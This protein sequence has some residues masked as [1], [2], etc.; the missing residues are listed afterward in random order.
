MTETPTTPGESQKNEFNCRLKKEG[1]NYD[2]KLSIENECLIV[3]I[4]QKYEDNAIEKYYKESYTIDFLQRIHKFFNLYD[5][6]TEAFN[7]IRSA[8]IKGSYKLEDNE[9]EIIL[10]IFC[11]DKEIRLAIQQDSQIDDRTITN[12]SNY[13]Q[14]L[15]EKFQNKMREIEEINKIFFKIKNKYQQLNKQNKELLE[16]NEKLIKE[17]KKLKQTMKA[18]KESASDMFNDKFESI[19]DAILMNNN[20]KAETKFQRDF[21]GKLRGDLVN[22]NTIAFDNICKA[23][24]CD[25]LSEDQT[26]IINTVLLY[27]GSRDGD[28]AKTFHEKCDYK[29]PTLTLVKTTTNFFFGGFTQEDWESIGKSKSSPC[30]FLFSLEKRI[31]ISQKVLKK[32]PTTGLP[33]VQ[34]LAVDMT[35]ILQIN[36]CIVKILI[37]VH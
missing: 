22:E 31:N 1:K 33:M 6:V 7:A 5:N 21:R 13:L 16:S 25:W 32:I 4:S 14:N 9:N 34:L 10:I 26:R 3:N 30:S 27:K 28:R 12:I 17:N 36:A 29:G 19:I 23:H 18:M 8:I 24:I 2:A 11:F 15:K 35:C 20:E 37:Q